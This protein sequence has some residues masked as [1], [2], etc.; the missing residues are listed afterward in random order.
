MHRLLLTLEDELD[1]VAPPSLFGLRKR[2]IMVMTTLGEL[3]KI[4]DHKPPN[5]Q[6][7]ERLDDMFDNVW[8]RQ[9]SGTMSILCLV[10]GAFG[11]V[12]IG[13]FT[14][15]LAGLLLC[16]FYFS[17]DFHIANVICY[18]TYSGLGVYLVTSELN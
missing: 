11:W 1:M 8:V 18:T 7:V 3:C 10:L 17:F 12:R 13:L 5:E 2:P 9:V 15:W 6:L 14:G 4:L 16:T